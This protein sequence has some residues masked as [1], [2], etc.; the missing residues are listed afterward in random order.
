MLLLETVLFILLSLTQE[1][2][3]GLFLWGREVLF[4][5][6]GP[7][8]WSLTCG[9]VKCGIGD[10]GRG[11]GFSLAILNCTPLHFQ[12]ETDAQKCSE[13]EKCSSEIWD[14]PQCN[15]SHWALRPWHMCLFSQ[16]FCPCEMLLWDLYSGL[17]LF[18]FCPCCSVF[19]LSYE[20]CLLGRLEEVLVMG[21]RMTEG[22]NHK[23]KHTK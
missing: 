20:R 12:A 4:E 5:R 19:S 6:P 17:L 7:R 2:M 1:H 9:S 11:G 23:V 10:T 21:M 18:L 22:I 14:S 3:G 13:H 16:T 15:L 8:L